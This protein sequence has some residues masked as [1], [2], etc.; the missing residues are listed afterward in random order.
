MRSFWN[1]PAACPV[2][3]DDIRNAEAQAL[4][5]ATGVNLFIAD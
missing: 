2:A 3:I 1:I 4:R 5:T